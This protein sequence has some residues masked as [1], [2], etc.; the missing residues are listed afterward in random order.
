MTIH[1]CWLDALARAG[2]ETRVTIE[3]RERADALTFEIVSDDARSDADLDRCA[4]VSRRSAA[5]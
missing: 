5:R 3:V 1:L 4:T 2:G